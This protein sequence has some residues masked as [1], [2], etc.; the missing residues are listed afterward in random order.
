MAHFKKSSD[1]SDMNT[2]PSFNPRFI[3]KLSGAICLAFAVTNPLFPARAQAPEEAA[4]VTKRRMDAVI[5]ALKS[6]K[7]LTKRYPSGLTLLLT[8]TVTPIK[9]SALLKEE[10]D[11]KDGWNNLFVYQTNNEYES[12][13]LISYGADGKRGGTGLNSDITEKSFGFSPRPEQFD[14]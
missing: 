4:I 11:I 12:F 14:Y 8:G 2:N 5:E 13:R 9:L 1:Y 3:R 7:Q 6:Y 10:S